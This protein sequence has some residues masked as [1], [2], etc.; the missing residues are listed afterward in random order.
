MEQY[1]L[2]VII[3]AYNV[4]KYIEKCVKSIMAQVFKNLEI[5][6]V[7]DGS[8]D[9]TGEL[10]DRLAIEDN[11]IRIIHK[12]NEGL[13]QARKDG[14]RNA[15][16]AYI[17][18]VDGDD[19]IEPNMIERMYTILDTENVDIA[20][21]GRDED[22]VDFHRPV[23]HGIKPGRYDKEALVSQVYPNMIV[24]GAFFEWGIFPTVWGKLF[25][26]EHLVAFQRMYGTNCLNENVW[27][28]FKWQWIID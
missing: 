17:T 10:V 13:V 22:T 27:S 26:R 15:T 7:D 19:W 25:R 11:R 23:Y 14:V 21:C 2:S 16:G 4:E 5:I 3:P 18:F 9:G 1:M 20:M 28:L 12:K 24:N 6:I 8:A